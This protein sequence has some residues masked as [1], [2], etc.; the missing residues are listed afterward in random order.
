MRNTNNLFET[1]WMEKFKLWNSSISLF[2]KEI[3]G[4]INEAESLKKELKIE[5]SDVFSGGLGGCNKMKAKFELKE[6]VQQVFKK[7]RNV[8][9]ASLKQIND[10]LDRLE[11]SGCFI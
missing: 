1:E 7:K 5:F 9:F 2:C 10:E 6:N 11:K 3:K 8:P 4:F